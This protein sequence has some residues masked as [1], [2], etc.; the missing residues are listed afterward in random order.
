YEHSSTYALD[1]GSFY[2]PRDYDK[3]AAPVTEWAE[4]VKQ[5]YP[6][7]ESSWQWELWNEPDIA[8]WQ[9]TFEEYA[10]L[11]DHTEAALHG[12]F[13]EASLGGPAVA[14]P[15]TDFFTR[16]LDHCATG[17]NA[18]TGETGT[19][20]D[21]VSFHAKGGVSLVDGHVQMNLGNQLRLHRFGF[22][23]VKSSERFANTP[24]VISEADP[25]GCAA[26]PVSTAPFNAYR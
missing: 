25:E 7:A 26:C 22:D 21:M 1:G 8:Y 20:L 14:T 11:Y 16:F 3:W 19:R 15:V 9:G 2:P 23:T 18:V 17:T 13:P 12:V 6:G 5:R 4:H 10:T 24:I